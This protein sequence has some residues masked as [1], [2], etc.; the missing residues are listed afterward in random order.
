MNTIL[1]IF[2]KELTDISRDRRTLLFM[3]I[4]PL[5]L[6]PI[7]MII[8]TSI[9]SSQEKKAREKIL[10]VGL[11]T[12]GNAE[13]FKEM[14]MNRDDMKIIENIEADSAE[15]LIQKNRLDAV[16]IFDK[17][18]DNKIGSLQI[19]E[20]ELYYRFSDQINITVRR[21]TELVN[22]FERRLLSE[23]F[24]SLE[25]DETIVKA[26]RIKRHDIA[27][28]QEKVG[29]TVGGFLPYIF[30][31]FCFMGGMYPAIDL[32]AGE[33][34]RGTMETLLTAPASRLQVLL[35]K[36]GVIITTGVASAVISILGL[37]IAVRY[38]MGSIIS[39]QQSQN[40]PQELMDIVMVILNFQSIVLIISLLIPLTIFFASL[41]LS[42]SVYAKSYKEAQ[43]IIS[44]LM[45]VII[46]PLLIGTMPGTSLDTVTALIPVLN[47]SLAAKDIV[48]GTISPSLL[49][50]V[51]LSL[52]ILAGL[53]LFGSVKWFSREDTIFRGS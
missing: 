48:A 2:K 46:L 49:I 1:T 45:I 21:L 26:V 5:L 4:I 42:L 32:G 31:I 36:L 3:V 15:A 53:S 34:E 40:F 6:F 28:M 18:F 50:E 9:Q 25:L 10:R 39:A 35:G 27:S 24:K 33:K 11:I 44:P 17:D 37:F 52:I 8:I 51:Y 12:Y 19:G 38:I 29:R 22:N 23:R 30:V 41:L 47:V 14:L 20:I 43:S 7:L 13:S 16:I